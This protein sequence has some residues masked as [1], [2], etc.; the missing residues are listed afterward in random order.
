M[1][2]KIIS[3]SVDP[4]VHSGFLKY[5]KEQGLVLSKQ[6]EIFMRGELEK[7]EEK[8]EEKDGKG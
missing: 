2:K 1:A 7:L 4:K 8:M 3:L 6:V 5:C